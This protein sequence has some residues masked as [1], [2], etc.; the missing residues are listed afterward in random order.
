MTHKWSVYSTCDAG[1]GCPPEPQRLIGLPPRDDV[2]A[3]E[4]IRP[5]G[6]APD[7]QLR[8]PAAGAV[9]PVAPL[10]CA[11]GRK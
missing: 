4:V 3:P 10:V 9:L 7:A 11:E 6:P 5:R 1:V 2:V 8:A